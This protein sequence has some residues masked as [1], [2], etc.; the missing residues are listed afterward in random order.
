MARHSF[1]QMSKLSNVKGR[2]SYITSHA[3]QEN[4]YATY[5][6]ADNEF[7][8]NLARESQQEFKRSG[9]EGKCIEARE[10]I[11]ALPEVYTRY[12]PQEVLEDF[13]EE[14]HRRYGVECVSALHHNKRKTN[15]HIHLIFS[16]RKL[17]P[18]PDIKI[19]T[20]SV[21]YDETGKRVRTKKEITG[22][23]GQI[24]KGCTVI[25]KGEVYESHLFTVKDDKFKSEPFLRE[26]KEIYTDLINRHI[27]DPEQQL[28]VFD[29]NSVY[30][31]TKKIGK[32]NPKAAEIETDNAARQEWNRT[33][34]MALISG[35]SEAKIL[36]VK[37]TEIHDKASQSIKSKGWLPNLFRGI[38]TKA[39]DFLQN[40][41][42]EKDMPPKP[43]LDINM[44]EF[45][46]MQKLMI[47]AQDKAKEI[48]HLQ[49]TVL[50]KLKQQLADT[51]G[52]FKGKERKALTEQI[53]RTEKE[54]AEKLDKLPD[55]LKEDG[56]PD[57]QAFMATYRKAEA[58]VEQY[59]RDLA[60]WEREVR[61]NRRPAEKERLTP[62]EKKSI[63]DQLRRLQAESRQRSQPKRKSHDRESRAVPLPCG[64]TYI[65]RQ[66]NTLQD[67]EVLQGI[68]G[69][70][71]N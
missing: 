48:R 6:T 52:I 25:K 38:V 61:E 5:R 53:Q 58:V 37:Q 17:L 42:Q 40:L 35:I 12:E 2:I 27:S 16:E 50:P 49:D 63:R 54:I 62:P 59:N 21:F 47:K 1:I 34:D 32:N 33:A 26:V 28:K 14:F 18:E 3:K 60:A 7:W 23:D 41:I 45:R 8:S 24:R 39:K 70:F 29:K 10:L 43:T 64:I 71:R 55:V 11:I 9:T 36:E 44:A 20:R 31:P 19:A 13:T 51:K 65:L 4:L 30:L 57:V 68:G 56:Y 69:S 66:R 22:E 15:Y 67:F 46:T